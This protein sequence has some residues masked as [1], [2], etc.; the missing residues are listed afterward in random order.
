MS[1]GLLSKCFNKITGTFNAV[2]EVTECARLE[3]VI[4]SESTYVVILFVV[5]CYTGLLRVL[6]SP[7]IIFSDFQFWKVLENRHGP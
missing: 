2:C 3:F 6:E 7:G 1:S 5:L 4:V